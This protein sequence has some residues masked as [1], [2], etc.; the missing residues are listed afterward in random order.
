MNN[1]IILPL[2]LLFITAC[3]LRKIHK[4]WLAPGAFFSLL[5]LFFIICPIVFA[6]EYYIPA[7][8][9]WIIFAICISVGIG[10]L[11]AISE[12]KI[13]TNNQ[14]AEIIKFS[15]LVKSGTIISSILSIIGLVLM[16]IY[17]ISRFNLD[18]SF[19]S[20]LILPNQISAERYNELLI[21]PIYI[22]FFIYWV[23]PAAMFG[24]IGYGISR[25]KKETLLY[26]SPLMIAVL[27]GT[28]ETVRTT[29][30]LAIV[31]WLA[32]YIGS[33]VATNDNLKKLLNKKTFVFLM[34]TGS[35]FIFLFIAIDWLR[36]AGGEMFTDLI[37]GRIKLYFFGYL[38]AFTTW[39]TYNYNIDYTLGMSTFAGPFDLLNLIDRKLGFYNHTHIYNIYFTNVYSSLRGLINDFSLFG[40]LLMGMIIGFLSTVTFNKTLNN[41][42]FWLF[43]LTSFYAFILYSPVISIFIYNSI[44]MSWII[45]FSYLFIFQRYKQKQV[46]SIY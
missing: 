8:G 26:L 6:P 31:V 14:T 5:W 25:T 28:I 33:R 11:F 37:I 7:F 10:S 23:F 9:I 38:S 17:T 15:S 44:I 36:F 39:V 16:L 34:I 29:I 43:P 32:A 46:D 20:F 19:I 30:L 41:N 18:Y 1:Q 27:K 45:V 35:L 40:T 3:L 4:S 21:L 2:I 42:I 13:E 24:G 22:K 12:N